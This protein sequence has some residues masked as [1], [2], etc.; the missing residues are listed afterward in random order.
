MIDPHLLLITTCCQ[1]HGSRTYQQSLR[2]IADRVTDWPAV[3]ALAQRHRVEGLVWGALSGAGVVPPEPVAGCLASRA[4][5]IAT[6]GLRLAAQSARLQQ[7]LD[8]AGVANLILKGV[9]LDILAWGRL[10][11]KDAW[12]IDIL[13]ARKQLGVAVACLIANGYALTGSLGLTLDGLET[14]ADFAKECAFTHTENGAVVEL[15]WQALDSTALAPSL[16]VASPWQ[17]VTLAPNVSVR[18]FADT[19]L[20]TYLCVHGAS[21]AWSRLKWLADLAA[22]L[23]QRSATEIETLYRQSKAMGAGA[24]PDQALG[25]CRELLNLSI[26]ADLAHEIQRDPKAV[27]LIKIA[28]S[29]ML[30]G[31]PVEIKDRPFVTDRILLSQL[32]LGHGWRYRWAE[33]RR[34]WIGV[35][36]RRRW[37]LPPALRG[38][39]GVIRLPSWIWRRLKRP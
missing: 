33:L 4:A 29:V 31:G 7:Q 35:H 12:D 14:W 32:L 23:S 1:R 30:G 13:I 36:D 28:K 37:P 10:G 5:T 22:W 15:H 26:S 39:Y 2:D 11:L 38:L 9:T 17:I 20:F 3:L 18:T 27:W 21:H 34:Q 25:L 19:E 16:G 6:Q 8:A 24:A